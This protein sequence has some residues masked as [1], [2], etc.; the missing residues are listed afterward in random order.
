M[1]GIVG[2]VNLSTDEPVSSGLLLSM[3]DTMEHRGP[4]DRGVWVPEHGQVGLAHRRLSIVDT[5]AAGHQPMSTPDGRV[6]VTFNGEIYNYPELKRDLESRGYVFR[7]ESDTEVLPY[8]YR[9]H[10]PSFY[11][12]LDGDFAIGLWDEGARRL[13][14]ARDRAGVKP[15]YY[16]EVGGRVV[17][18]SE[19]RAI[20]RHP[21]VGKEIDPEA[22]Y[23]YLT[24][25][26]APP[27]RTLI[28]GIYK[29]GA[30]SALVVDAGKGGLSEPFKYWEPFPDVDLT[31]SW[32]DL[33]EELAHLYNRSVE[34]RL[35]S[36]VPVGALFSGGVDSTLNVT[37]FSKLI[38]PRRV[39][40][41]TV[42][43]DNA[44]GF[45][46]DAAIAKDM[47]AR[48]GTDH[49]EIRISDTDLLNASAELASMQDEPVSDPVGIPIYFVTKL[50]K[51]CGVT[52][53]HAG[54]GAD[55]LFCGY[56]NY[57]NMLRRHRT[58]WRPLSVL[59]RSVSQFASSVT[60]V[61]GGRSSKLRKIRDVLLRRAK[62]QELF[63][64]SAV[65]YY[66]KEKQAVLSAEF[67]QS[68]RGMDSFDVVAPL[69]E[70]LKSE[71]PDATFLQTM[72]FIELAATSA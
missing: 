43:M 56:D 18:A 38:A 16:A 10:G 68:R 5:S 3:A 33:D 9:V 31:T 2:V 21:E 57:R 53:V 22:F 8:L 58:M 37:S 15:L 29:L 17:F 46:D 59:P 64:S 14:L 36:D 26:V 48:L 65:A 35:M 25:L 24:Y 1:C 40:T 72:T 60:S 34:K 6:W 41:F 70:R 39:S 69:Y 63:M 27:P 20:L 49:H 67:R 4:D 51:E 7:S 44:A 55:E 12:H 23:H 62:G 50:A 28:R 61:V 71:R 19:V 30:A 66:E 54:E 11:E 32:E 13:I 52:V 45:H 42:G 47:A